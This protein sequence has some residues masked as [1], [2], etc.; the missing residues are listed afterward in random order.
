M[1]PE[2]FEELLRSLAK[3]VGLPVLWKG[4]DGLAM[5]G[6]P[7]DL[8]A[9][10]NDFCLAVKSVRAGFRRCMEDDAVRCFDH[11]RR[12]GRPYLRKCH[13]GVVDLIVP[14]T[15]GCALEGCL[16]V[17][18]GVDPGSS[19]PLSRLERPYRELPVID[20]DRLMGAVPTLR[21]AADTIAQ[22]R[23]SMR[24]KALVTQTPD[25]TVAQALDY[26]TSNLDAKLDIDTVARACYTSRSRFTALF[27][28]HT[29]QP[30][31]DYIQAR[32]IEEAK[33]LLGS[34][35]RDLRTV[36]FQTGFSSQS[37]FCTVFR[38]R[39]GMTPRA[40]VRKIRG[41]RVP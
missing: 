20:R 18:A 25:P 38:K 24:A 39:T 26:V 28:Q 6:S 23:A 37:Y 33:A 40:Y 15:S 5:P 36:A 32:R 13:A 31:A 34:T 9:H 8:G 21:L 29:G 12:T 27:R 1:N 14:G 11:L 22:Y 4:I 3:L 30:F 41:Q 35:T 16:F 7:R 19:C 17:G 10:Q 2:T